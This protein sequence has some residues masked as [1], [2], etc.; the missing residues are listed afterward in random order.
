MKL[1]SLKELITGKS[2]ETIECT[3]LQSCL[4]SGT[5]RNEG[6]IL[7]LL[8]SEAIYLEGCGRVEIK[9]DPKIAAKIEKLRKEIPPV[10]E[11][12]PVPDYLTKHPKCFHQ[13]WEVTQKIAVWQRHEHECFLLYVRGRGLTADEQIHLE[14]IIHNTQER[15]DSVDLIIK[16][17]MPLLAVIS[18]DRLESLGNIR[19]ALMKAAA[20]LTELKDKHREEIARLQ[21]ECS[22]SILE[23]VSDATK[24]QK[25]A[26]KAARELFDL[27][28]EA[29]GLSK[30]HLDHLYSGSALFVKYEKPRPRASDLKVAWTED[31][32]ETVSQIAGN[33]HALASQYAFHRTNADKLA[34]LAAE[35]EKE[36]AT[37]K[38]AMSKAA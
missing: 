18:E 7:Y 2:P 30:A 1:K 9:P 13:L 6:E 33:I 3:V 22:K 10:P 26:S 28:L 37:A 32:G 12:A 21:F 27:R 14:R 34:P 16:E 8:P 23:L 17:K 38:K 20:K 4:I 35:V 11:S 24:S 29:L 25:R 31:N 36:L 19:K 5:P 15:A